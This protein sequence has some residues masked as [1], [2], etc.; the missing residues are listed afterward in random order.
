MA[1]V[2]SILIPVTTSGNQNKKNLI[3][4]L[5]KRVILTEV[6]NKS[7]GQTFEVQ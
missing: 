1:L 6:Y 2:V 5:L 3:I 7:T 4:T